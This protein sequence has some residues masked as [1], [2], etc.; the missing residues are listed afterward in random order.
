MTSPCLYTPTCPEP[1]A[2]RYDDG[3]LLRTLSRFAGNLARASDVKAFLTEL[4]DAATA[5]LGLHGG[6]VNVSKGDELVYVTAVNPQ[7]AELEQVQQD[8]GEGPCHDAFQSGTVVVF[9]DLRDTADRWPTY[10]AAAARHGIVSAAGIPL[11]LV[12]QRVGAL[13][14]YST[15]VRVWS[16]RDVVA[17]QVLADI[18]TAHV[19]NA[20]KLDQQRQLS[21]QLQR[22]LDSRVL[23]E[24]AKGI[25]A[26]T[27]GITVDA[28]FRRIRG[29]CRDHNATLRSVATAIVDGHLRV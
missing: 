15:E 4:T 21:E 8:S 20:F 19:V 12:D 9:P 5:A 3:L 18:A 17:A 10:A 7:V 25:I 16:D 14:L 1:Q 2:T 29:Y 22:A 23:I 26:N 13:D 27:H 28:A 11:T 6:G 24:Q